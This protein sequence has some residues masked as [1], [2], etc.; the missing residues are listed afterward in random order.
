MHD[1]KRK[2]AAN[3]KTCLMMKCSTNVN[4]KV[5]QTEVWCAADN[6]AF[7]MPTDELVHKKQMSGILFLSCGNVYTQCRG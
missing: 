5:L 6:A 1:Q 4:V 3:H 7:T 2:N